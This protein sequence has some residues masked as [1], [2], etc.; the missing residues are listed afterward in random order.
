M[1]EGSVELPLQSSKW[2]GRHSQQG[3]YIRN[4]SSIAKEIYM[5][6]QIK[7]SKKDYISQFFMHPLSQSACHF[8]SQ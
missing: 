7:L 4:H 8:C 5:S 3:K 6:T 2:P 1:C